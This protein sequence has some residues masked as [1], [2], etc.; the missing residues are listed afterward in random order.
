MKFKFLTILSG[1][2]ISELIG[3]NYNPI[4][5][6]EDKIIEDKKKLKEYKDK[7][8]DFMKKYQD[9]EKKI[10]VKNVIFFF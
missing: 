7:H 9:Y 2:F 1:K 3:G 5:E 6:M 8:Q 4:M 10:K